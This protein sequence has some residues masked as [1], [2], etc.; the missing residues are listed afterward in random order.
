[1]MGWFW[2]LLLI[3][4]TLLASWWGMMAVHEAG[5]VAAAIATGG[6]VQEVEL[7][8]WTISRTDVSPNPSPLVV[9]WAGPIVGVT[10]PLLA[11]LIVRKL[12]PVVAP[13]LRFFAGFCL[14]TN[15]AYLAFGS[16]NHIGDAGDLLRHGADTWQLWLFG[17]VCI[18][19]GLWLWNGLG[20][21]F[22]LGR[23]AKPV[24]R[25]LAIGTT[26]FAALLFVTLTFSG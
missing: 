24:N 6:T 3:A 7:S 22:G 21:H 23:N 14:I 26:I 4:S 18:P 20:K 5:H 9:V 2:K 1:M 25:R 13:L 12:A 16:L 19:A 10:L 17:L 15:G 8:P 11:W